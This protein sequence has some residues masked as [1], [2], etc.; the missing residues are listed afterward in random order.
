MFD[1]LKG[2][3]QQRRA[4]LHRLTKMIAIAH[5]FI[6]IESLKHL[7]DTA[8]WTSSTYVR[9]ISR[10][11]QDSGQ[12]MNRVDACPAGE[13]PAAIIVPSVWG[14]KDVNGARE[15]EKGTPPP[16]PLPCHAR[17][18]SDGDRSIDGGSHHTVLHSDHTPNTIMHACT[19]QV[20]APAPHSSP[21]HSRFYS[22]TP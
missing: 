1:R 4:S 17:A 2:P 21:R 5:I 6:A 16:M 18:R 20:K 14:E 10:P 13:R 7:L 8:E 9:T 12:L 22:A 11:D 15:H 3:A 19:A